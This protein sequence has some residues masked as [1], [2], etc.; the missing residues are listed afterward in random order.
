MPL[1]INSNS[2]SQT[3]AN[4][5]SALVK[6]QQDHLRRL[7]SGEKGAAD[8]AAAV[9]IAE[10]F[11]AQISSLGQS[12]QN[13]YDGLSLTQTAEGSLGE[14][15][16]ILGELQQ[17]SVQA[18]NGT[19]SEQDKET[20]QQQAD[21][22]LSQLDQVAGGAEFNGINLLDGSASSVEVGVGAGAAPGVDSISI[23]LPTVTTSAL[24]LSGL[25]ITASGVAEK[26][27]SAISSVASARA[28]FGSKENRLSSSIANLS[29]RITN[30]TDARSRIRDI[31]YARESSAYANSSIR[32]QAAIAIQAQANLQPQ[33]VLALLS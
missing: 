33:T 21:D 26:I 17:I 22:L 24:G 32:T 13:A 10:R 8:D 12:S 16:D 7:S 19:L 30:L 2:S 25:D 31:D 5:L 3:A 11:A 9:A 20:L 27:E 6:K 28:G 15:S 4:H 29:D 1:V 23:D 14:V 18:Q